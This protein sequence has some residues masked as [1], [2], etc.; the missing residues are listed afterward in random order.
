MSGNALPQDYHS[1]ISASAEKFDFG[2]KIFET[3]GENDPNK[4]RAQIKDFQPNKVIAVGGDGT[5]NMVAVELLKTEIELGIIPSGSANGLAYNI[6]I[7]V[8]FRR[9]LSFNLE[10]PANPMDVI[11]INDRFYCLH[12]SD[13]GINARIVKRFEKEGKRTHWVWQ[14]IV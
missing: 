8:N 10:N 2:W 4:I 6:G 7:P 12:L 5:V 11:K 14:A 3:T 13:V 9:A 1:I